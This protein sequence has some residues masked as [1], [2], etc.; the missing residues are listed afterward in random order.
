VF[1]A[2]ARVTLTT[3]DR[4]V[5]TLA[6]DDPKAIATILKTLMGVNTLS[7][8][9]TKKLFLMIA[10]DD[11]QLMGPIQQRLDQILAGN[12]VVPTQP[13]AH[14]PTK[15]ELEEAYEKDQELEKAGRFKSVLCGE[16]R[17]SERLGNSL[18]RAKLGPHQLL[19]LTREQLLDDHKK[20]NVGPPSIDLILEKRRPVPEAL[21]E[22]ELIY[23]T[24]VGD[25]DL[26]WKLYSKLVDRGWAPKAILGASDEDFARDGFDEDEI[27]IILNRRRPVKED[28]SS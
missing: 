12:S 20:R 3:N 25:W 28:T 24:M 19:L 10:E 26:S 2:N 8:E 13:P 14:I 18:K 17:L 15:E 27:R 1:F 9:N 22:Q 16:W 21:T 23:K 11:N 5:M 6:T 4:E 7:P